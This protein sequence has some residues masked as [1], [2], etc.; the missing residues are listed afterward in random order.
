MAMSESYEDAVL[1]D[2]AKKAVVA[3]KR[4][5]VLAAVSSVHFP[6]NEGQREYLRGVIA[7]SV[8]PEVGP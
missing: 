4:Q 1:Y 5:S 3:S 2:E 6:L 7:E 8:V